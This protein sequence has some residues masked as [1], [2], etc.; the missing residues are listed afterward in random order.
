MQKSK[1]VS[2]CNSTS[3]LGNSVSRAH[4]RHAPANRMPSKMANTF[5]TEK[6][7]VL[8]QSDI[9][10]LRRENAQLKKE[11]WTL[12]DEYDR[13]GKLLTTSNRSVHDYDGTMT[14]DS[15]YETGYDY[16]YDD[17]DHCSCGCLS[18]EVRTSQARRRTA[19]AYYLD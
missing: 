12:R 2:E 4:A 15:F 3:I 9:K 13:L 5:P 10:K 8:G 1:E 19:N 7:I 11:I 17:M 14:T 18:N 16:N 6:P